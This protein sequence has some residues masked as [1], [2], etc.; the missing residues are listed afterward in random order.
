MLLALGP[1]LS[2]GAAGC[3]QAVSG[4]DVEAPQKKHQRELPTTTVR[5]DDIYEASDA[6]TTKPDELSVSE[7]DSAL[8]Q[9]DLGANSSEDSGSS[10]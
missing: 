1:S 7:S 2:D 3:F 5:L 9:S 4:S 10:N 6:V 8:R